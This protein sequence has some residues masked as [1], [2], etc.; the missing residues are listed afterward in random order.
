VI[1]S[2]R[3]EILEDEPFLRRLIVATITQELGAWAWPQPMRDH[4][5]GIQYQ[6]RRTGVRA[7]F[8]GGSSEIILMNGIDVGWLC[9]ADL[10]DQI[11]LVEI[12]V[13]AEHRGKGVGAAVIREVIATA[14]RCGKPVR[15]RVNVMN[16]GA[17]RLYQR[18]GFQRIGGDEVQHV[19][20][21]PPGG[22]DV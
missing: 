5:L 13:L 15:L 10:D 12:M 20:E 8:S 9:T 7:N 4:L 21:H 6:S 17:I 11:R 16:P 1:I 18:L 19:M 14:K 2:R 22:R 3:P